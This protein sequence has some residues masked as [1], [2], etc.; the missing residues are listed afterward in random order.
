M[1]ARYPFYLLAD[2]HAGHLKE[3]EV[4]RAAPLV[5]SQC[6]GT[7]ATGSSMSACLT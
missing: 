5:L 2:S 4:G 7:S 6:M 1:G 3:A